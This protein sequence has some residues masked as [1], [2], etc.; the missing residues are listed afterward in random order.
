MKKFLIY[1]ISILLL[2]FSSCYDDSKN[3]T[4]RINLGNFQA[5]HAAAEKP[6]IDRILMLF[7]KE[8][9]A[10]SAPG[11]LLRI[12]IGIYNGR[13][14]VEKR[15]LSLSDIP[16][17]QI[18]ELEVPAGDNRT[19][20]ILGENNLNQAG[21]YGYNTVNLTAGE[22]ADV[23]IDIDAA[24]WEPLYNP[25]PLYPRSFVLDD[26]LTPIRFFWTGSGV[27][28]KYYV[29]E[30]FTGTPVYSGY[31]LETEYTGSEYSFNFYV[32]FEDFGLRTPPSNLNFG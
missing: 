16:V 9:Y 15:S 11:D 5:F 27:R 18:I 6:V 17:S 8:A 23:T 28:T 26:S 21:Y 13:I 2:I 4:L 1:I 14:L 20:L 7:S 12:H 10:Q 25:D 19:I 29:V 30:E 24:Y 3:A 32:E 31:G 22:T